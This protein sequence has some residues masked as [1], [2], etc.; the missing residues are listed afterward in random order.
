LFYEAQQDPLCYAGTRVLINKADIREQAE[1]D[2][3]E[4][5]MYLSRAA[6]PLPAG[7]LDYAHYRA[8]HHHLFQD[9]YGWAGKERTIRIAKG[10]STFAYPEHLHRTM[11]AIFDE[12]SARNFLRDL[13]NPAF[14][15]GAAHI[16]A[17]INA[18]HPFR[19]GNG[20]TQL[21]FLTLLCV[22][23]GHGFDDDVLDPELTLQAMV[24][25][26]RGD[27]APLTA[28]IAGLID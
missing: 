4:L 23:S 2:E 9:V 10:G 1:L 3:F 8:I 12:L 14:A 25:S 15:Q 16:L 21:A 6:E 26:F 18:G 7:K 28:L 22:D 27:L 19:E 20:R 17:E 24:S 5:S 11:T 13:D